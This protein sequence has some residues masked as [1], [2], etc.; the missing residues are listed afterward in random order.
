MSK[1]N[2][3]IKAFN[4]MYGMP[5]PQVPVISRVTFPDRLDLLE[6]LA[7]FKLILLEELDEVHELQVSINRGASEIDILTELADWLGDLQVYCA[8]EMAKFG[9]DNEAVLSLIMASNM[10]KLGE[11]GKPIY[12]ERGK[13]CKGPGYWKPEPAIKKY[14]EVARNS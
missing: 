1:F 2:E 8:S 7:K 14:I 3:Q 6:R 5:A 4:T 10:S 12:D 13:V 11:D 9:L